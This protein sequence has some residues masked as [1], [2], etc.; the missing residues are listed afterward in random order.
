MSAGEGLSVGELLLQADTTARGLLFDVSGQDAPEM[1]RTWGEV[2]Q[3]AAE[4]WHAL[5]GRAKGDPAGGQLMAQLE[6]IT[7]GMHR[8]QLR[9][10]WPGDGPSDE[11]LLGLAEAFAAARDLV[12]RHAGPSDGTRSLEAMRDVQAARART[13]HALYVG[14]HAVG[15]AVREHVRGLQQMPWVDKQWAK[16]TRGI[17]RGQDALE[18]LNA[19][20]QLAGSYLGGR[21]VSSLGGERREGYAGLARLNDA[22]AR[23]GLRAHRT[24][25]AAATPANLAAIARTT[26]VLN[27]ANLILIR[28]AVHTGAADPVTYEQQIAPAFEEAIRAQSHL[29][30]QWGSLTNAAT[31]KVDPRLWSAADQLQAATRE[32]IHDKTV[33]ADPT[34]IAERADL[35]D[36]AEVVKPATV[37]GFTLACDARE[38]AAHSGSLTAPARAMLEFVRNDRGVRGEGDDDHASAAMTLDVYAGLFGDDLDAVGEAMGS[39]LTLDPS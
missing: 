26:A 13:V 17:P 2:V 10:G 28:A 34:L 12:E 15:V 21:M 8:T 24:L 25:A 37:N 14:S 11:R 16:V 5:P 9:Q 20:E 4:L 33:L 30:G 39:L 18:R 32:L 6:S 31:R 38:I 7:R 27:R 22:V 1:L 19:F 23:W 3:N 36:L 29:A 35:R